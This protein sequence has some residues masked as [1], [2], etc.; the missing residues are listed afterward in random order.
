MQ[1]LS[2]VF[3]LLFTL[4]IDKSIY[5]LYFDHNT[6]KDKRDYLGTISISLF[7]SSVIVLILIFIFKN[8]ITQIYSSIDFYPFYFYAILSAFFSV[9]SLIPKIYF[10]VNSKPFPFFIL[11]ISQFILN[12]AL[13]LWLIVLKD[14]GAAGMLKGNMIGNLILMPVFVYILFKII[15]FKFKT[16]I[17]KESLSYSLPMIPGFI[18]AWLINQSD[19]VFIERLMDVSN[20]GLYS[21][22]Y[23]IAS[24]G[25]V[26]ASAFNSAYS[27]IFYNLA[28]SKAQ[29]GIKK[30]LSKYNSIY[31]VCLVVITFFLILF[32]KELIFIFTDLKYREAYHLIPI[33][34][35]G[36][37]FT[38]A[39]GVL[40]LMVYQEKKVKQMVLIGVSGGLINLFFN[41]ILIPR[42]GMYG[43]A[44]STL[45][46]FILM[47]SFAYWY[48]KKCYFVPL[49]WNLILKS[50]MYLFIIFILFQNFLDQLSFYT[51]FLIKSILVFGIFLYFTIKN[52]DLLKT[53]LK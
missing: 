14:E 13:V 22:A 19:R 39:Q 51:Q 23:K 34:C 21:V 24:L 28:N 12:T 41:F 31:I 32:S 1:V 52:F 5:R 4:S 2:T 16:E 37:F 26:I 25:A 53:F 38:Q 49:N 43:A 42:Y 20:V 30:T 47:F 48:A 36:L 18:A 8:F 27:P 40:N 33:I 7:I 11:S 35:I 3:I 6:E 15:H 44:Y 50:I 29:E 17:L 9:Y 10:Q 45:I 46:T